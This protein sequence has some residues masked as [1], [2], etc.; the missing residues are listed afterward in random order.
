MDSSSQLYWGGG[1]ELTTNAELAI[2]RPKVVGGGSIVN[3]ALMDR[4]DDV[5]LDDF[6]SASGVDFLASDALAPY[7]ERAEGNLVLQE[8]PEQHRN[9]NAAIFAGGFERNG[10]R[11]APLRRAQADCRFDD[12]NSCIE[13][14][15]G[16]RVDSKQSTAITALP[17]AEQHGLTLL[18]QVEVD[19]IEERGDHVVVRGLVGPPGHQGRRQEWS[20]QRVVLAGGAIGNSRLLLASGYGGRLPALGRNFFTHPQFMNFGVFDEPVHAHRGPLQN[21]KSADPGFRRQGF[22]LENVFAGPASIAM[23][24]PGYGRAHM[25]RMRDYDHFGCVE[26]CVRDT[27]PGRIRLGRKGQLLIEKRMD[28]VDRQRRRAGADAIRNIF[29]SMGAR[30]V[31]EGDVGIGLHLM[32]GCAIGTDPTRSVVGPDFTLHGS[33]RIHA[34][35]SSIFP[36]APGINPALTIAALSL[37]ASESILEAAR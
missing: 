21:Y 33:S 8:V 9:G 37:K 12:G 4:F 10:Y 31:I 18:D 13:C 1:V 19:Q 16:C 6:R 30:E 27:N 36:K 5:A 29:L 2:L 28:A 25:R 34:A 23:L 26:V 24:M 3:Q 35:D 22:K 11:Y 17:I 20:A 14:L 32:G 7:Y 15:G